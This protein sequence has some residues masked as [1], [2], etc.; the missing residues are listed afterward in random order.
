MHLSK[1]TTTLPDST[2]RGS[3]T[4]RVSALDTQGLVEVMKAWPVNSDNDE[5]KEEEEEKEAMLIALHACGDLTVFALKAFC[6]LEQERPNTKRQAI[7]VGCCYNLLDPKGKSSLSSHDLDSEVINKFYFVDFPLSKHVT[8][9]I[10]TNSLPPLSMAHL[11]ISPQAPSTW[12]LTPPNLTLAFRAYLDAEILALRELGFNELFPDEIK[13]GRIGFS[14]T[15]ELYREKAFKRLGLTE[16]QREGLPRILFGLG[17]TVEERKLEWEDAV[18]KLKV[19]WTLRANLGP[20]VES[21]L[22]IDRFAMM[23]EGMKG[24]WERKEGRKVEL[25]NLFDQET[26]SL[27][28][29]AIVV[30]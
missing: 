24:S 23:I 13:V 20:V 16:E 21:F 14:E 22:I 27:R 30:K 28:N 25:F 15:Y 2:I 5:K 8:S 12:Y 4:H 6:Q 3:L 10:D 9:L 17:E 7:L 19:W 1:P 29:T 11:K 26:G 18:Y